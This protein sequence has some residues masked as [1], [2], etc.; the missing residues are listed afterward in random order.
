[1]P[2]QTESFCSR[3]GK[4]QYVGKALSELLE[5][6]ANGNQLLIFK[7]HLHWLAFGA[8]YCTP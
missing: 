7:H 4:V 3:Q 2:S 8:K 6:L 5:T 1:M